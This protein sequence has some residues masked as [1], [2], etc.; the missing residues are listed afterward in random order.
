VVRALW[1]AWRPFEREVL[2]VFVIVM[3]LVGERRPVGVLR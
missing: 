1:P 3:L 2:G